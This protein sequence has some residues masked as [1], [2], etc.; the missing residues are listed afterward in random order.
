MP[1][2]AQVDDF[3]VEKRWARGSD[4]FCFACTCHFDDEVPREARRVQIERLCIGLPAIVDIDEDAAAAER[5]S[6]FED[7]LRLEIAHPEAVLRQK[8]VALCDGQA[9]PRVVGLVHQNRE[10][11]L[12]VHTSFGGRT[13]A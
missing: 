3:S 11:H 4:R 12:A 10:L 8:V 9:M 1:N 6:F 7:A 13:H 5:V 2:R